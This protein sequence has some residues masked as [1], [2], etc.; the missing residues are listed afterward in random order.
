MVIIFSFAHDITKPYIKVEV[1]FQNGEKF[2]A[3]T[4]I[5]LNEMMNEI[6]V[7]NKYLVFLKVYARKVDGFLCNYVSC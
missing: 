4:F 3:Y 5:Q 2:M 1:S 6:E 7:S